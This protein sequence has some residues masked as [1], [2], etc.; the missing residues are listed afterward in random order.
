MTYRH[1][2]FTSQHTSDIRHTAAS[3]NV[4]DDALARLHV[5]SVLSPVHIDLAVITTEQ[6]SLD[7]VD[8]SVQ[9]FYCKFEYLYLPSAERKI[10]C[11]TSTGSTRPFVPHRHQHAIF[12]ALHS[13][14]HPGI[15]STTRFFWINMCRVLTS[16][17]RFC[18]QC[19][20][21]KVL[22]YFRALLGKFSPPDA[23]FC[24]MHS[25]LVCLGPL[26][27]GSHIF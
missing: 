25:D 1:L 4:S 13:L 15:A 3:A 10:L 24:H 14:L 12:D 6:T 2:D 22:P 20:C 17:A 18:L 19:Q 23:R 21:P 9:F 8:T 11:N 7:F 5:S 16:W 27:E 26:V